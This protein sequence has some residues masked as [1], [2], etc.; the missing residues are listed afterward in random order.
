MITTLLF[1]NESKPTALTEKQ[2]VFNL[3]FC[4]FDR[5]EFHTVRTEN[6]GR[7]SNSFSANFD[8]E[9]FQTCG[10]LNS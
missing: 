6:C 3:A 9:K 5:F 4:K 8:D 1:V 10:Q 2:T 7:V